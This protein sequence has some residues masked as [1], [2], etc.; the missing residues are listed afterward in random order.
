MVRVCTERYSYA[1]AVLGVVILFVGLSVC[2]SVRL[3]DT[4]VH[5]DKPKQCTEDILIPDERAITLVL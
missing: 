1:S 2:L 5:C 3:S 4:H